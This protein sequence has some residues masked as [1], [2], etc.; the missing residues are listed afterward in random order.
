MPRGHTSPHGAKRHCDRRVGTALYTG[1]S[2]ESVNRLGTDFFKFITPR[3][4]CMYAPHFLTPPHPS[5]LVS[6]KAEDPLGILRISRC[7]AQRLGIFCKPRTPNT[8]LCNVGVCTYTTSPRG[9]ALCHQ[10]RWVHRTPAISPYANW[11]WFF[12][13]TR[14]LAAAC[15]VKQ[16]RGMNFLITCVSRTSRMSGLSHGLFPFLFAFVLFLF[17]FARSVMI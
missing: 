4:A 3:V 8:C 6:D 10:G 15:D 9:L 2:G 7:D 11:A 5:A 1:C 16:R 13:V 17:V 14:F 12:A